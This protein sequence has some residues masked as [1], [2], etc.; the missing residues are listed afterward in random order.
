M[1]GRSNRVLR[2]AAD[3]L[4]LRGARSA[5]CALCGPPLHNFGLLVGMR[6]WCWRDSNSCAAPISP[7]CQSLPLAAHATTI[8]RIGPWPPRRNLAHLHWHRWRPAL[9]QALPWRLQ[10]L[11]AVY[12]P[13]PVIAG[14]NECE[15]TGTLRFTQLVVF[16]SSRAY[17]EVPAL[18]VLIAVARRGSS[19]S[20]FSSACYVPV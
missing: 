17:P 5:R 6:R 9:K 3:H 4:W 7:V 20:P 1:A 10:N 12:G 18:T 15:V 14:P 8:C 11:A 19:I 13:I 2:F 16:L